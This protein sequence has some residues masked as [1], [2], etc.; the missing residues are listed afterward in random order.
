MYYMQCVSLACDT[1]LPCALTSH[2]LSVHSAQ[3]VSMATQGAVTFDVVKEAAM[4]EDGFVSKSGEFSNS[5]WTI[6]PKRMRD[7]GVTKASARCSSAVRS[8]QLTRAALRSNSLICSRPCLSSFPP[9]LSKRC[10]FVARRLEGARQHLAE[11]FRGCGAC[12]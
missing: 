9:H 7:L 3:I 12:G 2:L 8:R 4:G 6:N 5:L 11:R 1:A 10:T